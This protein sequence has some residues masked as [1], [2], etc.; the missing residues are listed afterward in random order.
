LQPGEIT[1]KA[2][3]IKCG[4]KGKGADA[5][6]NVIRGFEDDKILIIFGEDEGGLERRNTPSNNH[7]PEMLWFGIGRGGIT[8]LALNVFLHLLQTL[9]E[10]NIIPKDIMQK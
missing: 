10:S 2:I 9:H 3:F 1:I 7:I 8:I 6:A 4:P 5:S